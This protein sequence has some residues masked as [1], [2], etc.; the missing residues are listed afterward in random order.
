M[1]VLYTGTGWNTTPN[2]TRVLFLR[3]PDFLIESFFNLLRQR[4]PVIG[5]E[6]NHFEGAIRI[7]QRTPVRQGAFLDDQQDRLRPAE[8]IQQQREQDA[9]LLLE[10]AEFIDDQG[11]LP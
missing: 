7:Q 1:R 3:I 8:R 4:I 11:P 6:V 9:G 10:H 2:K 5:G